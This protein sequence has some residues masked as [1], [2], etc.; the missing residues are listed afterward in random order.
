VIVNNKKLAEYETYW[1]KAKDRIQR[2]VKT[3][4]SF[5]VHNRR[6]VNEALCKGQYFFT[7]IRKEGI[8]LYELDDEPLAEPAPLTPREAYE[9]ARENFQDRFTSATEFMPGVELYMGRKN[10]RKAAFLLQQA[11]EHAYSALLLTL[12]NYS[13][14]SHNIA[15]LRSLA[16]ERDRRLVDAW[17]RD[18]QR[19]RAWFNRL[20][21]AYVKARYSKHYMISE[22]ALLWLGGRV[23]QLCALVE[24]VRK[25]HLAKLKTKAN[26]A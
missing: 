21:E 23:E 5:I 10:W 2:A 16:E 4:V 8:V 17:P 18:L 11:I 7:D 14:P 3:P 25:E 24:T 19:Y 9:T 22:E 6:F 12:T 20:A 26:I 13:P 1:H 15:F